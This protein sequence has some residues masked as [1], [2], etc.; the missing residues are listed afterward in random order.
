MA[1][2]WNAPVRDYTSEPLIA[3]EPT[4]PLAQ[5]RR[6][7]DDN[8][9]SAVAVTEASRLVGILSSTDLLREARIGLTGPDRLVRTTAPA[10]VAADLMR[11]DVVTIDEGQPL[12]EA[13]VRMIERR[14]HRLIVLRKEAPVGV[15][16]TR[17]AMRSVFRG[18]VTTPLSE[19]MTANV[20]TVEGTESV[21]IAIERLD[22]ANVHGLVVVDGTWPIGVFTH[23][24]ALRARALHS[25]LKELP[26]ER[27]M[28]YETICL[29][30]RT[31]LY[32][33]AGHALALRVR[34]ILAVDE[35]RLRGIVT[36]FDL[37]RVM[38]A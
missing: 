36:G 14:I 38:V 29:N 35:R 8:D 25:G 11:T 3:V 12:R 34:R 9:V 30:V 33:V 4:T 17:D 21:S 16:S 32:R 18:Q 37:L 10:Q 28:S 5:V 31:A 27:V 13:A 19:V 23:T 26:V 6:L 1:A 2:R 24:E 15:I 7:L 20:L 22:D